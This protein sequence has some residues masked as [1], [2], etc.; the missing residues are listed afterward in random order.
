MHVLTVFRKV[1]VEL[2]TYCKT[3]LIGALILV[4]AQ[5]LH[6]ALRQLSCHKS[7]LEAKLLPIENLQVEIE[8]IRATRRDAIESVV[9]SNLVIPILALLDTF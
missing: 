1:V 4:K 3:K 5:R 9:L 6:D 7:A 2:L 8:I